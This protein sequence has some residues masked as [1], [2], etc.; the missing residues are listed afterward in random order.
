MEIQFVFY[1]GISWLDE[2]LFASQEISGTFRFFSL[3]H[4]TDNNYFVVQQFL[5]QSARYFNSINYL[6]LCR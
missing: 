3:V 4:I 2:E 5:V 6:N 1:P